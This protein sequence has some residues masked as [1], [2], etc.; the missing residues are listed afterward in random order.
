MWDDETRYAVIRGK[1]AR[2]DGHF[3]TAVLTTGIYCRPSCP[4]RTPAR[5]NVTFYP[6]AAAAQH[7]GF[8]SCRRCFPDDAPGSPRWKVGQDVASR[9]VRLID[10]GVVEREGVAGLARRLGYTERHV[11]RVL[12]DELGASP[13]ALAIAHRLHH[14]RTLL[15]TTAMPVADVA[16]AAG[17]GSVRQFNDAARTAWALAPSEVR[18][19]AGA[20]ASAGPAALELRLR[21]REPAAVERTLAFVGARAVEGVETWDGAAYGRTMRLPHGSG[22]VTLA[23]E[24]G[25]VRARL[26]LAD[27]R[28]LG[29][30][31]ARCRRLLDLDADPAAVDEALAASSLLA[32]LVAAVPGLRV[33][34]AVDPFEMVVRAIVGQQVSVVGARRT[35]GAMVTRF[36]EEAPAPADGLQRVFPSPEA[37]ADVDPTIGLVPRTRWRAISTAARAMLDGSLDLGPGADRAEARTALLAI[38]GIGPWTAEYVALRALGDPDAFPAGDLVLQKAA[39]LDARALAAAAEDWRPWRAYAA[40]HLWTAVTE[41][42]IS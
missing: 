31:V 30:A 39:G 16:F 5:A 4:A 40:M 10:D 15:E 23:A 34:G 14:A 17:F 7:A 11:S 13:Q 36:G 6:S 41:G 26:A 38:P 33:P 2:Y 18:R 35:L 8:R 20:R 3:V 12:V 29:A 24:A 28:D 42:R 9:A 37:L 32:P 21:H 25:H 22:T 1:D 27:V 19:R